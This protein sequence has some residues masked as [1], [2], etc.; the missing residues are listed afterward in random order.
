MPKNFHIVLNDGFWDL[1]ADG[2]PRA[3]SRHKTRDEAIRV[4]RAAAERL[5]VSLRVEDERAEAADDVE[6]TEEAETSS[7]STFQMDCGIARMAAA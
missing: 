7:P 2:V 6:E 4:G 1:R 3:I 5:K